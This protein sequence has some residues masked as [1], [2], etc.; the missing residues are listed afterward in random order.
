MQTDNIKNK[1]LSIKITDLKDFE[2]VKEGLS[3]KKI[4]KG[5]QG[6]LPKGTREISVE[7]TNRKGQQVARMQKVPL[8]RSKKLR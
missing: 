3:Y 6:A 7:Y 1:Q 4:I 2:E 5:V 8:G